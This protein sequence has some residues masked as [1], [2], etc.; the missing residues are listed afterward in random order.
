MRL[1]DTRDAYGV[2]SIVNHWATA[3][4][5]IAAIALGWI[6]EDLERGALKGNLAMVHM[7]I[8]MLVLA[9][10]LL[11]IG[12]RSAGSTPRPVGDARGFKQTAARIGHWA[13]I[14]MILI[15]PISGIL[16]QIGEGRPVGLFGLVLIPASGQV[17]EALAGIGHVVH[18][19]G[20]N[21]LIALIAVHVLAALKHHVL[22]RDATLVR[23]LGRSAQAEAVP[24]S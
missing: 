3:I 14:V 16:L 23:M 18:G 21:L 5:I 13:L 2:V 22:D 11:R 12:W 19:L 9:L 10:G 20:T 8:G 17:I 7:S 24:G 1:K 15:M 4:L 6:F